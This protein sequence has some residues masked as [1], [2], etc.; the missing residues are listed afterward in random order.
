VVPAA[1]RDPLLPKRPRGRPPKHGYRVGGP[2][3]SA[4]GAAEAGGSPGSADA[5][6]EVRR[7]R[8]RT[9]RLQAE[10][11]SLRGARTPFDASQL[12]GPVNEA[13]SANIVIPAADGH[14]A[15]EL[16]V[17]RQGSALVFATLDAPTDIDGLPGYGGG[18]TATGVFETNHFMTGVFRLGPRAVKDWEVPQDQ[19]QL[20]YVVAAQPRA[21]E[22]RL[23]D[24]A[25]K[26][27]FLTAGDHVFAPVGVPYRFVNHSLLTGAELV[28]TVLRQQPMMDAEME[29]PMQHEPGVDSTAAAEVAVVD[30]DGDADSLVLADTQP[31][32]SHAEAGIAVKDETEMADGADDLGEN[33]GV[34]RSTLAAAGVASTAG[35]E[36]EASVVDTGDVDHMASPRP[37]YASPRRDAG[38][39]STATDGGYLEVPPSSAA[40]TPTQPPPGSP[41]G[42]RG[43]QPRGGGSA[44]RTQ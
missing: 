6:A 30:G 15:A 3:A 13:D 19:G 11:E 43:S 28:F 22:L 31:A 1:R 23:D 36:A 5:R 33:Q 2:F 9:E 17:F 26:S 27:F 18:P 12:P 7:L 21:L 20:F 8:Q 4:S 24:H 29:E 32:H 10:L 41:S 42:R 25:Q 37:S 35:E 14:P 40:R 39:A 16:A 44:L 38:D 34:N